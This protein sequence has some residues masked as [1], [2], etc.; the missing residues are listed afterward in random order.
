MK[1]AQF[2]CVGF[3][4][5]VLDYTCLLE[6]YP[7]LDEKVELSKFEKHGGGPVPTALATLAR[8]GANTAFIGKVGTD[9][10]GEYIRAELAADDVNVAY[11]VKDSKAVTP[12]AYI[13][14]DKPTGKRSVVLNR[15][16]MTDMTLNEI[17][18]GAVT[19]GRI[20]LID[21]QEVETTIGI[22]QQ[23]KSDGITVVAD[24]GSLRARNE[25]MLRFVDYPVVSEKF[26]RQFFGEIDPVEAAE[27]LLQWGAEAAVVT[28]G[29]KGAFAA[30]RYGNIHQPAFRV[31]VVDTNGAG[32]VF[33]GGFIFGLIQNW[34]L[35]K[36]LRFASAV[37]AIKCTA[38][39]SRPSIPDLKSV[40][41]FLVKQ[42]AFRI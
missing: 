14:I 33:H 28:C 10:E 27:K 24:F 40:E 6:K 16:Q 2:D 25:E 41:A 1:E 29:P 20:L 42:G 18:P 9:T 21:G 19:S 36:I 7:K 3:G 26:I 34:A 23:A 30:T 17:A 39:G 22:M 5:C 38:L 4:I 13:W 32:D 8:L 11:M 12:C 31:E 15:H 37:S 35:P